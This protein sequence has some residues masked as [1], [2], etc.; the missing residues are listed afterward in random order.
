[1]SV[2]TMKLGEDLAEAIG[3]VAVN[4]II[5]SG[6]VRVEGPDGCEEHGH[7]FIYA[8]NACEQIGQTILERFRVKEKEMTTEMSEMSEEARLVTKNVRVGDMVWFFDNSPDPRAAIVTAVHSQ[9]CVNLAV[10][11]PCGDLV[12]NP[13]TSVLMLQGE[14]KLGENTVWCRWPPERP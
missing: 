10:F 3:Q 4:T 2:L 6:L 1:M 12:S 13:P 11:L 9:E 7:V 5:E 14:T 8:A